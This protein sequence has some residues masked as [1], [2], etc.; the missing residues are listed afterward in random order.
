MNKPTVAVI[1]LLSATMSGYTFAQASNDKPLTALPYSPSLDVTSM[2]RTADP[3]EDLYTYSC[4]LWQKKNP[5]PADQATWSVYSKVTADNQRFLWG[6]LQEAA[7]P[8]PTR[9]P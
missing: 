2:D 4:G 5:I 3:C 9:T 7:K 1:A 6:V 8:S